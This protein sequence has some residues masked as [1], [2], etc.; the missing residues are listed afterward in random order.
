ML[1][2]V[3]QCRLELTQGDITLQEVDAIV[4]AAN[5]GLVGGGGVDGAIHRRGG[6][7]IMAETDERYPEGCPTGSAVITGAGE[8][9]AKY[10]IHAVGPVWRGGLRGEPELLAGCYRTAL[11]LAVQHHCRSIAFPAISTGLYAYPLEE[12]AAIALRTIIDF[13]PTQSEL[14][15]VRCCLFLPDVMT[16]FAAELSQLTQEM[17]KAAGRN[18]S[19]SCPYE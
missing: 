13:L 12:A 4:N 5:S 14:T 15:L 19:E 18:E 7:A 1:V 10:V 9:R 6:P 8:L 2:T 16:A 11:Q 17:K 3:G